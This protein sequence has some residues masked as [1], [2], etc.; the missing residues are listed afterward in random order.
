[1]VYN[2]ECDRDTGIQMVSFG[3]LTSVLTIL[4]LYAGYK[5]RVLHILWRLD[6]EE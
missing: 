4:T 6:D 1:M 3:V 5:A 2:R